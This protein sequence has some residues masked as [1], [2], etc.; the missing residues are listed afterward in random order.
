[1]HRSALNHWL[2][3]NSCTPNY[4]PCRSDLAHAQTIV[5]E[6]DI[7]KVCDL[8][9]ALA[10]RCCLLHPFKTLRVLARGLI[11]V[12]QVVL[13]VTAHQRGSAGRKTCPRQQKTECILRA[14]KY[15]TMERTHV[16]RL[17][18]CWSHSSCPM[19]RSTVQ[20]GTVGFGTD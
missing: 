19:L 1:M 20:S 15:A 14:A 12:V 8:Q 7:V 10:S 13:R 18:E 6:V 16:Y 2:S 4:L 9:D 17:H 11:R 3:E 5:C